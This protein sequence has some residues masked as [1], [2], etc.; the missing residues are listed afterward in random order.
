VILAVHTKAAAIDFAAALL[1]LE[2]CR[3][4]SASSGRE[5]LQISRAFPGTIDLAIADVDLPDLRRTDLCS[6]LFEERLGIRMLVT[7]G[8]DMERGR[9]AGSHLPSLQGM[10]DGKRLKAEIHAIL[11]AP[12]P[13]FPYVHM[14][15]LDGQALD[16]PR[17]ACG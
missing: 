1:E 11:T 17:G 13:S 10:L 6:C 14:V 12:V 3:V 15:C 2:G 16:G 5:A 4:L 8:T 7:S 9:D